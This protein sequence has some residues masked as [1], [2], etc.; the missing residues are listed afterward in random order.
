[1][2]KYLL[3]IL[4]ANSS[5]ALFAQKTEEKKVV[6]KG[7]RIV[8]Q[9]AANAVTEVKII[10]KS[11]YVLVD[12]S[13]DDMV[14]L[15]LEISGKNV[16]T[17]DEA[18]ILAKLG[19]QV[20]SNT[21]VLSIAAINS[22][23]IN[24]LIYKE[25]ENQQHP[26]FQYYPVIRLSIPKR[27]ALNFNATGSEI[28][29][30][31]FYETVFLALYKT[32]FKAT[33]IKNLTASQD[34]STVTADH[35]EHAKIQLDNGVLRGNRID[36]LFVESKNSNIDYKRI[37]FL[38]L[39]SEIDDYRIR[40]VDVVYG[41]KKFK[42]FRIDTLHKRIDINGSSM[43]LTINTVLQSVDSLKIINKYGRI[44]ID[45]SNVKNYTASIA[46]LRYLNMPSDVIL[47][48]KN[49]D[50]RIT[51]IDIASSGYSSN[52]I[53]TFLFSKGNSKAKP[54]YINMDCSDCALNI[55]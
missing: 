49:D 10:S 35:I 4:L 45:L 1:M 46:G 33:N 2:L 19:I 23:R 15:T 48:P 8:R 36:T 14:R 21:S 6:L 7:K 3:L 17:L 54:T 30:R 24:N 16:S 20:E 28:N 50:I 26:V 27:L 31:D 40:S 51:P 22:L 34:L 41:Q 18:E 39:K 13:D 42:G 47:S 29:L 52:A 44:N 55:K 11:N 12:W 38:S 25:G 5:Y 9:Y 53:T 43:D 37:N 32:S